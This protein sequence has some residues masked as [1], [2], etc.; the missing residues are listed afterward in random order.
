MVDLKKI[1][2]KPGDVFSKIN[3]LAE[4]IPEGI[5][6]TL[7][8]I[9]IL[10]FVIGCG[11]SIFN[12]YQE[13]FSSAKEEGMELA[14]DTKTLFL[15]D[16]ERNYNRKRKD[17]RATGDL[18]KLLS[19]DDYNP[20]KSYQGYNRESDTREGN[21]PLVDIKTQP[22]EREGAIQSIKSSGDVAPLA[23]IY[24]NSEGLTPETD[25]PSSAKRNYM[26]L[27]DEFEGSN[28][29]RS[30]DFY[31][32]RLRETPNYN[33]QVVERKPEGNKIKFDALDPTLLKDE[34]PI[35]RSNQRL[36][37]PKKLRSSDRIVSPE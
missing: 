26:P 22:L 12:G 35:D 13:G 29:G 25:R 11:I 33:N 23:E 2:I 21:Q 37:S 16:I 14:K 27:K 3:D 5:A 7:K 18:S 32:N 19:E 9:G 30:N 34:V 4:N 1:N 15:E 17:V 36:V 6:K 10:L 28:S 20:Q 8:T 24:S 31:N